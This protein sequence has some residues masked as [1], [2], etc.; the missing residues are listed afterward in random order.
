[1]I[2][3]GARPHKGVLLYGPPG[4]RLAHAHTSRI[5][6]HCVKYHLSALR[7]SRRHAHCPPSPS[8]AA[9]RRSPGRRRRRRGATS[10][11]S[12]AGSCSACG[13]ARARRCGALP[14]ALSAALHPAADASP[15]ACPSRPCEQAVASLFA[16]A[17]A[18]APSVIFFDELDGLAA[19]RGGG[20][21]GAA[22]ESTGVGARVLTQLLTE[23]DGAPSAPPSWPSVSFSP[24]RCVACAF[25]YW[26]YPTQE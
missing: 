25:C 22:S 23:M 24:H 12:R 14:N 7:P 4:C 20:E 21:G 15:H 3:M 8:R 18:L 6:P 1:M 26:P 11:L 2:K 13:W 10:S 16:R 19:S 5:P 9:R 17:R